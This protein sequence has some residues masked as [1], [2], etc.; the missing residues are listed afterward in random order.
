MATMAYNLALIP[1]IN[2][3]VADL[4]VLS[5]VVG[6]Q[7]KATLTLLYGRITHNDLA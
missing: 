3:P 4:P 1:H 2:I 5:I 6:W 7:L